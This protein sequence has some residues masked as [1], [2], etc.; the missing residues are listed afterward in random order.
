MKHD[1]GIPSA[2]LSIIYL[3]RLSELLSVLNKEM[4]RLF[5]A[6]ER[7]PIALVSA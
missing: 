3:D 6:T 7:F 5:T 1:V 2:E 4:A